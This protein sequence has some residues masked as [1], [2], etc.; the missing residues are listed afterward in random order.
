[1]SI[2]AMNWALGKETG[3]PS[4]KV[5]LLTLANYANQNG[6]AFPSHEQLAEETEQSTDTVARRLR[7]LAKLG[8]I[9]QTYRYSSNTNG[10]RRS[11]EYVVLHDDRARGYARDLGWEE[12]SDGDEEQF[13]REAGEQAERA[14]E[15]ETA[16]A[17]DCGLTPD[18]V[19]PQIEGRLTRNGAGYS[20]EDSNLEPKP[21]PPLP[22]KGGMG[23]RA[24]RFD[25]FKKVW[26][27]DLVDLVEPARRLFLRLCDEDQALAVK[28]A[29][30][31]VE[32]CRAQ[33]RKRMTAANWLRGKGWQAFNAK[34]D[35]AAVATVF[36]REGSPQWLAWERWH[37]EA[38]DVRMPSG[39][40]FA[41]DMKIGRGRYE[42]SEWPPPKPKDG[43]AA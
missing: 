30:S 5:V 35:T 8:L 13:V 41:V 9:Y 22:P 29:P 2:Q 1:M 10:G 18:E 21:L 25:E 6:A 36:I 28:W 19:N 24:S 27:F 37:R 32:A 38:K 42:K 12:L 11:N 4:A 43:D 15:A 40:L 26:P 39:K 31:Y 3:S 33:T 14:A 34:P 16:Y 7:E 23:G 17:A 20:K